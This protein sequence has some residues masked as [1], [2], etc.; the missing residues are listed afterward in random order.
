MFIAF[1]FLVVFLSVSTTCSFYYRHKSRLAC[2]CSLV[3]QSVALTG[4]ASVPDD[5]D[6]LSACAC[7]WKQRTRL[8]VE[9]EHYRFRGYRRRR[10]EPVRFHNCHSQVNNSH[11]VSARHAGEAI[12][13][14][15]Q[16]RRGIFLRA[17]VGGR[18]SAVHHRSGDHQL[19]N[20]G[21]ESGHN[22]RISRFS[23]CDRTEVS[24]GRDSIAAAQHQTILLRLVDVSSHHGVVSSSSETR[25]QI[26]SQLTLRIV[27]LTAHLV[28]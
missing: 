28:Q 15:P 2:E 4:R 3:N 6:R 19:W 21:S 26:E 12:L 11:R 25:Y 22:Q 23:R 10:S 1:I 5:W 8:R 20:R 7:C 13:V 18:L 16:Q 27:S 24:N 17:W 9:A 14:Q